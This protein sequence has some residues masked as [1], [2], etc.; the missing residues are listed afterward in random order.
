VKE[1]FYNNGRKRDRKDKITYVRR[2]NFNQVVGHVKRPQIQEI[3]KD[4]TEAEPG[5]QGY[6]GGYQQALATV[7]KDLSQEEVEEYK[8]MAVEWSNKSPPKEV[9]RK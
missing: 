9:Q 1:W 2:W 8:K 4:E 7:M 6:M 5:T 3:C